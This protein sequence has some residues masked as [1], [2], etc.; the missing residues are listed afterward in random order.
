MPA[1]E[2]PLEA[3]PVIALWLL[4]FCEVLFCDERKGIAEKI[5][6]NEKHNPGNFIARG[7]LAEE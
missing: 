1:D 3:D 6:S 7:I 2:A 4:G 5:T